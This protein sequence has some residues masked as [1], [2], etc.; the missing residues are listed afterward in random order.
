MAIKMEPIETEV[1]HFTRI[2]LLVGDA[3]EAGEGADHGRSRRPWVGI[4]FECCGVYARVCR[5]PEMDWYRGRCPRCLRTV[6]LRVGPGG[7]A[8]RFFVG[9]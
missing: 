4:L 8:A 1:P 5:Q 9:R 3:V 7:T 6:T 2:D